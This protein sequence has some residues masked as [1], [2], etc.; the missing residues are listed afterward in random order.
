MQ[1]V[2]SLISII[3]VVCGP[4]IQQKQISECLSNDKIHFD[5]LERGLGV[6]S[7]TQFAH[8]LSRKIFLTLHSITWANF[9]FW[10]PL[11]LQ[12]L[13]KMFITR[14]PPPPARLEGTEFAQNRKYDIQ[15]YA[16][17]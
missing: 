1:V 3:L 5:S 8:G 17:L 16:M 14:T 9:I 13:G 2:S 15:I 4:H 12:I 6:V 7:K 10:L 11:L